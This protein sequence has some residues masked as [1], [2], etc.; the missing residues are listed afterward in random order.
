MQPINVPLIV[1]DRIVASIVQKRRVLMSVRAQAAANIVQ[2]FNAPK[3]V[4]GRIVANIVQNKVAPAN[5]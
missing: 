5:V 3:I 2:G 4:W 1:Q